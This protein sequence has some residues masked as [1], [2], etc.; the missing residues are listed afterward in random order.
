MIFGEMNYLAVLV[1]AVV[2]FAIS[3][4]WYMPKVAGSA[5]LKETGLKVEEL[6]DPK[7]AMIKSFGA[8]IVLAFGVAYMIG[9][10]G[11]LGWQEGALLGLTLGV[12]IH[13]AAGFPNYAFENRSL[14]LFAIHMGNSLLG[15]TA[16][17]AILGV[18]Q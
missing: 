14:R 10:T 16:M 15:M 17:G 3:G 7:P 9:L 4:I 12:A 13:G 8:A 2:S 18:W 6:I 11:A 5:W 1:A